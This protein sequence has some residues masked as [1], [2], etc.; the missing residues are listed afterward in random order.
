MPINGLGE[1]VG[2]VIETAL[3]TA[4]SVGKPERRPGCWRVAYWVSAIFA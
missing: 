1:T 4:L 2:A 3:E